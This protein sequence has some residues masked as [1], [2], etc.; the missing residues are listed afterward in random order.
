MP[1]WELKIIKEMTNFEEDEMVYFDKL[2]EEISKFDENNN[3][4][5]FNVP[6][7]LDLGF[8][9]FQKKELNEL[10]KLS[11]EELPKDFSFAFN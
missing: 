5:L 7:T 11:F 8:D 10:V 2:D 4:I 6:C 1:D 9:F 3:F